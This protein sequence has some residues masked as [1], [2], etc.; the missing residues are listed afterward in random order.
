MNVKLV[1]GSIFGVVVLVGI[2]LGIYFGTKSGSED[3]PVTDEPV[4]DEP[5]TEKWI[6]S[7]TCEPQTPESCRLNNHSN[8]VMMIS[9]DG[10]RMEYLDQYIKQTPY[11]QKMKR[12]NIHIPY[13]R[14]SYPTVTFPNHFSIATG[15]YTESHGIVDNSFNDFELDDYFTL[16]RSGNSKWWLA[17]PIWNTVRRN[18]KT[19][20]VIYWPGSENPLTDPNDPT[21][22]ALTPNYFYD[23]NEEDPYERRVR[24]LLDWVDGIHAETGGK[25]PSPPDL[26]LG[27]FDQPDHNGHEF[28]P[29]N[30]APEIGEILAYMDQTIGSLIEGLIERDQFNCI[31]LI[32]VADHGMANTPV[33]KHFYLE[34][35]L[36]NLDMENDIFVRLGVPSSIGQNLDDKDGSVWNNFSKE[37]VKNSLN[38][39]LNALSLEQNYNQPDKSLLFA[40]KD[41]PKRLHWQSSDRINEYCLLMEDEVSVQK[42]RAN[43]YDTKGGHGFD[44]EQNTMHALF[45]ANGN[46]FKDQFTDNY[47]H[48]NVEI[49]NLIANLLDLEKK[50]PNN[51]T[52]GALNH[53]LN[54]DFR[55]EVNHPVDRIDQI[56]NKSTNENLLGACPTNSLEE[57][58]VDS[59]DVLNAK[60]LSLSEF[61]E[62]EYLDKHLPYGMAFRDEILDS[63]FQLENLNKM[64]YKDYVAFE[65]PKMISFSLNRK[66]GR[67]EKLNQKNLKCTRNDPR[68]VNGCPNDDNNSPG[69]RTYNFMFPPQFS[70]N[71]YSQS[72]AVICSNVMPDGIS[73]YTLQFYHAV[74]ERYMKQWIDG[75]EG[76]LN[77]MVGFIYDKDLNGRADVPNDSKFYLEEIPTHMFLIFTNMNSDRTFK[78]LEIRAHIIPNWTEQPCD[79]DVSSNDFIR[80]QLEL[81]YATVNDIELLTGLSFF[82]KSYGTGVHIVSE[83]LNLPAWTDDFWPQIENT[84]KIDYSTWRLPYSGNNDIEDISY[85][86]KIY[87]IELSNEEL[88]KPENSLKEKY[89][90]VKDFVAYFKF[91]SAQT[92]IVMHA[93]SINFNG[94]IMIYDNEKNQVQ[95]L[96]NYFT[97]VEDPFADYDYLVIYLPKPMTDIELHFKDYRAEY[98]PLTGLYRSTYDNKNIIGSQGQP[99]H[100]RQI[101]PN[102]DE[103]AFKAQISIEVC[104]HVDS[105]QN[106]NYFA[107]SNM[108][109]KTRIIDPKNEGLTC[110]QFNQSPK[111][112]SYLFALTITDF[113]SVQA[114]ANE[115]VT[116]TIYG[117]QSYVSD[118]KLDL[119]QKISPRIIDGFEGYFNV[120]YPLPKSDQLGL[121]DFDAGAMEN[122]GLVIYRESAIAYDDR[123]DDEISRN[124]VTQ[125]ISHELS[126][127]WFGN[128][129]TVAWWNE[130]FLNEGFATYVSHIGMNFFND[131]LKYDLKGK[132]L[133]DC[134]NNA[135]TADQL[136]GSRAII[137]PNVNTKL[138]ILETFDSISYDKGASVIRMIHS[139]VGEEIFKQGLMEYLTAYEFGTSSYLNLLQSWQNVISRGELKTVIKL[140]ESGETIIEIMENW[141][142]QPGFPVVKVIQCNNADHPELK[143]DQKYWCI[144][145]ERFLQTDDPEIVDKFSDFTWW[146]PL[147][148]KEIVEMY[149]VKADN[150]LNKYNEFIFDEKDVWFPAGQKE[151]VLGLMEKFD[152]N[153]LDPSTKGKLTKYSPILDQQSA[154]VFRTLYETVRLPF[155][156]FDVNNSTDLSN[157]QANDLYFLGRYIID[158]YAG[159]PNQ[160]VGNNQQLQNSNSHQD[161]NQL[162]TA[163]ERALQLNL[164][165]FGDEI[166]EISY[167]WTRALDTLK[168]FNKLEDHAAQSIYVDNAGNQKAKEISPKLL[169]FSRTSTVNLFDQFSGMKS[170]PA[171][172]RQNIGGSA[173]NQ[174]AIVNAA[175]YFDNQDCQNFIINMLDDLRSNKNNDISLLRIDPNLK[176]SVYCNMNWY[177]SKNSEENNVFELFVDYYTSETV[178]NNPQEAKLVRKALAC[179]AN[180]TKI[181]RLIDLSFDDSFIRAQDAWYLLSYL[182][183]HPGLGNNMVASYITNITTFRK[184]VIRYS[185][186]IQRI[187][188]SLCV[189]QSTSAEIDL[190]LQLLD[191]MTEAERNVSEGDL[192]NAIETVGKNI[193]LRSAFEEEIQI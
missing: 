17:D 89:F 8:R 193:D 149:T 22:E 53:I 63:S 50:S 98:G 111:M 119:A 150:S 129:V 141:L 156:A 21:S 162:I 176:A 155:D 144:T 54:S 48:Q 88:A 3:E 85:E 131:E 94:Q 182:A 118:G 7:E 128:L 190:Y 70:S 29:D 183:Q 151:M 84:D 42:T 59:E 192:R 10:F 105:D 80:R 122:W 121:P 165:G 130:T 12:C 191:N 137:D 20:A 79:F 186:R 177:D 1:L 46:A 14:S 61:Q 115:R 78:P 147:N 92:K 2:S 159:Y 6:D 168:S 71:L 127:Q 187:L 108:N 136:P 109:I 86:V 157:L 167:H 152:E 23:Y 74:T 172:T 82:P 135:F 126:H 30:G 164:N 73:D 161:V 169:N 138:N 15:M 36:T 64:V 173:L 33:S 51:G 47:I 11:F 140:P 27:Y 178:Q 163:I 104:Y 34:D 113:G 100:A 166:S 83:K 93:N 90:K 35:Y 87:D 69:K 67:S 132:I 160:K 52:E 4:T 125:V 148:Y 5:V 44:N 143:Q 77:V 145:Q 40:K 43:A 106:D 56:G 9:L 39:K 38:C 55:L 188:E 133:E 81:H 180:Q 103:P 16:S 117:R 153:G 19:S 101:F 45:L 72:D 171:E 134:Y 28:G 76:E 185:Y 75:E 116:T 31:N 49:Y 139:I 114:E 179:T 99:F 25:L 175:C 24:V 58:F 26:M 120:E 96:E 123:Y 112:S 66:S 37:E 154:G 65:N 170:Y 142:V 18:N 102:F 146:I 57:T 41:M 13:M 174:A 107:T 110:V 189:I 158:F 68:A 62:Q 184:S 181:E 95:P 60:F 91:S 124:Y 97:T 32:L